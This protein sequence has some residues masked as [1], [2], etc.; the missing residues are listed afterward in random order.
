MGDVFG[1]VK[2]A[3]ATVPN[4]RALTAPVDGDC[5]AVAPMVTAA[6]HRLQ[7]P[8][9]TAPRIARAP[10]PFTGRP[11]ARVAVLTR[12]T[13]STESPLHRSRECHEHRT[14]S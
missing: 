12:P 9:E 11:R 6:L 1:A 2:P 14:G 5:R 3:P 10:K 13:S 4:S 8:T 7:V